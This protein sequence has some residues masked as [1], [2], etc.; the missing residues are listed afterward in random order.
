MYDGGV[1]RISVLLSNKD[2]VALIE[3]SSPA[4]S[5]Q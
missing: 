4:E 2:C 5:W 1:Y 3:C